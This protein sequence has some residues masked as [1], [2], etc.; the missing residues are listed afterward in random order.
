[1]NI[2]IIVEAIPPYCG[3]AEHAAWNKALILKKY[4]TVS[5]ITF[6]SEDC[7]AFLEGIHVYYL[8]KRRKQLSYYFTAGRK[9]IHN[10]LKMIN[11]DIIH[12]HMPDVLHFCL[13]K[14]RYNL[15]STIHDGVPETK[16]VAIQGHS[17]LHWLKFKVMRRYNIAKSKIVTCVSKYNYQI[18]TRLYNKQR[19]K[20]AVIPNGISES[21]YTPV[22]SDQGQFILNFGRQ[23]ELKMG[24]LIEVA[25]LMPNMQFKFLGNGPMV[26]DYGVRN[27]EFVGFRAK[28]KEMIDQAFFCVFPSVSENLPLVGLESMARG[29]PVIATKT[30]FSEYII[31]GENGILLS[32]REPQTIKAAIELL[33]ADESLYDRLC[34]NGRSTAE[35][36]R[37][38]VIIDKYRELYDGLLGRNNQALKKY[39]PDGNSL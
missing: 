30:G 24:P 28:V 6:G 34:R 3:G 32:D 15:I 27:V 7:Y 2:L 26:Q 1:M 14:N 8:K 38:T 10:Y 37:S 21:F 18:M 4:D 39:Q 22:N 12:S 11:P 13:P 33:L 9:K 17:P 20:F 19:G 5:I 36:Y 31:D 25:Q 35:Q 23:I 29:R 16:M